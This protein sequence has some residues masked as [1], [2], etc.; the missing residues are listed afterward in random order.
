MRVYQLILALLMLLASF[1][2]QAFDWRNLWS[3]PEQ[4]AAKHLEQED[5]DTLVQ[6]APDAAWQGIGEYRQGDYEAAS[7]SF[8]R[9]HE[10]AQATGSTPGMVSAQYN[11]ANAEVLAG[12]YEQALNLYDEVLELDPEHDDAKHNKEIAEQLWKQQ[13]QSGEQNNQ[14]DGEQQDSDSGNQQQGQPPDQQQGQSQEQQGQ[15]Q[16]QQQNSQSS[17]QQQNASQ[18]GQ[19]EDQSAAQSSAEAQQAEDQKA[20]EAMQ[21]ERDK[22]EADQQSQSNQLSDQQSNADARS[23]T[24]NQLTEQQQATEQ[25]L[26][27][28]P[29]DPAGLLQRKLQNR[30]MT[31]YPEVRDSAKP[32]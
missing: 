5:F 28:I 17:E 14:Q 7:E 24:N 13:Q 12:N 31:D 2:V 3:S 4:R 16:E 25:W 10:Q 29:D 11:R 20:A 18:S 21:A 1:N 23:S 19:Q 32:W 8:S 22:D 6:E 30:H 15:S 27:Q 9:Q 26:R